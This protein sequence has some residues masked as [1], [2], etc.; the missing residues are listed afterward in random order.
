M[1]IHME[2]FKEILKKH[3]LTIAI[4]FAIVLA[5]TFLI[6]WSITKAVS[7]PEKYQL[8]AESTNINFD[9]EQV[10]AH[11]AADGIAVVG[12]S[13]NIKTEEKTISDPAA[14]WQEDTGTHN[15][16][17]LPEAV[18]MDDTSIGVLT[19]PDIGLSVRV[20][21]SENQMEDMGKG[22]S[23]F[24]STS[25]WFG[26]VGLSAHNVNPDGTNGYFL[27]L[28]QI[29]NGAELTYKTGLGERV[30]T[31]ESVSEIAQ[32][33]W[34]LLKRT[35]DNRLTLITC[36]TGKPNLRLCVQAVEK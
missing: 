5:V 36:I 12:S 24:K 23:H 2:Q 27:N 29:K 15:N 22:A 11:T 8:T 18:Q 28:H 14:I 35:E 34:S 13:Q 4:G 10:K 31:V 26:N 9:A 3:W 7:K 20:F 16:F 25:C 21:E 19:I 33:D 30:Y 32:D 1:V 17:T 6:A